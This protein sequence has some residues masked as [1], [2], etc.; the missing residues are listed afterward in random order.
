MILELSIVVL[1]IIAFIVIRRMTGAWFSAS[2]KVEGSESIVTI[3]ISQN[4]D[5]IEFFDFVAVE[6]EKKQKTKKPKK[7][8]G[9]KSKQKNAEENNEEKLFF[10]RTELKK[11]DVIEF[12]YPLSLKPI[13]LIAKKG[14]ETTEFE[15]SP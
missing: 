10:K 7:R 6:K 9:K 13:T 1:V 15:L 5:S 8:K 3:H 11:G 4:F 12:K 14:D 2:K